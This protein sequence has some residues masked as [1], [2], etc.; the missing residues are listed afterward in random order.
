MCYYDFY[1]EIVFG[2]VCWFWDY[3]CCSGVIGY[4]L[5]FLGGVDSLLVVVIVGCM[6]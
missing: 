6:C 5:F 4:L 1:E 2:L 3:L